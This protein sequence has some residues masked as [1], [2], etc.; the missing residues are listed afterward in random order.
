[1]AEWEEY[2]RAFISLQEQIDERELDSWDQAEQET[3]AII[4]EGIGKGYLRESGMVIVPGPRMF[5][6]TARSE[7][8]QD[9]I[10]PRHLTPYWQHTVRQLRGDRVR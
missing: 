6:D 2:W 7:L 4:K 5:S 9:D 10:C 1:M 8:V 3:V